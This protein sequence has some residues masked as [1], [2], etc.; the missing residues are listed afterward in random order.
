MSSDG[1]SWAPFGPS[2]G[3]EEEAGFK[4][5]TPPPVTP[6]AWP[7]PS[8]QE[9]EAA[10]APQPPPAPAPPPV[11]Q[12]QGPP[13]APYG[14]PVVRTS[15]NATAALVLGIVGIFMCPLVASVP[16]IALGSSAKREIRENPGMGG[17]GM[18]TWGIALGWVG[19][20]FG[21]LGLLILLLGLA[22]V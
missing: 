12:W 20:A 17:E 15:G 8:A 21:A 10:P 13:P 9:P 2:E 1:G 19:T 11:H 16:A 14:S 3:D 4:P 22:S 6:L 7:A 18:A 5:P